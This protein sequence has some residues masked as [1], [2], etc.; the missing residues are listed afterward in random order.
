LTSTSRPAATLAKTHA[1]T[2]PTAAIATPTPQVAAPTV[3]G[4]SVA[5]RPLEVYHFGTGSRQLLIVAGIHGGYEWNTI[6]LAD[7]FIALLRD[8]PD[9]I[10]PEVSLFI[11][12]ALN[13]DG[14]AR[15]HGSEGRANENGV[16]LNRN[17]PTDWHL[18]W[19]RRYRWNYLADHGRPSSAL[20]TGNGR[21]PALH[22]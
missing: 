15:S 4:T 8:E 16:D 21:H 19:D 3:I 5:G 20:R 22:P 10:P 9:R 12:R 18:D 14:E 11:L 13:P 2:A 6:A 7:R 1:T 17:W